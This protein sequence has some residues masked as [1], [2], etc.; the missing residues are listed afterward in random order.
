MCFEVL[1]PPLQFTLGSIA[2]CHAPELEWSVRHSGPH[3]SV[4]E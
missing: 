2:I 1:T 4:K 3:L